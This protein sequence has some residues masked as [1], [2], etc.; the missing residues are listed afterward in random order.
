MPNLPALIRD[1][2]GVVCMGGYNSLAEVMATDTPALV[3]PRNTRRAE[4]PIRARALA[5]AGITD[6][7]DIAELTPRRLSDWMADAAT[8]RV[9]RDHVDLDGLHRVGHLATDLLAEVSSHV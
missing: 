7:A 4:Q 8:R 6:T 3:I 5:A 1:A 9:S 2:A